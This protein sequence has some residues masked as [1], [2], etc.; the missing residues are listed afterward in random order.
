MSKNEDNPKLIDLRQLLSACISLSNAACAIIRNVQQSR[1]HNNDDDDN[2]NNNDNSKSFVAILKDPTDTRSYLTV[3]DQRAQQVIVDGLLG[4]WPELSIVA[5]EEEREKGW[6]IPV[7]YTTCV[8]KDALDSDLNYFDRTRTTMMTTTMTMPTPSPSPTTDATK[9]DLDY[10]QPLQDVCVF[11][12]PVDGTREFVEGRLL[13]CQCL[14]G[15]ALRGKSVGGVMGLPF[16]HN[17]TSCGGGTEEQTTQTVCQEVV[18]DPPSSASGVVIY[19]LG[20]CVRGLEEVVVVDDD[21]EEEQQQ[22]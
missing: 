16:H 5:E 10:L 7:E 17:E 20:D 22:Q 18:S 14:I 15:I 1:E 13:S 12:D 4:E 9:K 6:D 2:N 8:R 21:E 3:A 19:A 11:I